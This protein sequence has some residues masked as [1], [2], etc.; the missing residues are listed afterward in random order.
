MPAWTGR[1]LSTIQLRAPLSF[2]SPFSQPGRIPLCSM[3][4]DI[5]ALRNLLIFAS[6]DDLRR[7]DPLLVF[8]LL[9]V[10]R[11]MEIRFRCLSSGGIVACYPVRI[12]ILLRFESVIIELTRAAGRLWRLISWTT[13]SSH[14]WR[15][16]AEALR[17]LLRAFACGSVRRPCRGPMSCSSLESLNLD[18]R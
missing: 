8:P 13:E 1:D 18:S 17:S 4:G 12:I 2:L 9:H 3:M 7:K 16:P 5:C 14:V 6:P 11:L 10:F 15:W